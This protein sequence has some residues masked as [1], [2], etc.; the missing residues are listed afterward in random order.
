MLLPGATTVWSHSTQRGRQVPCP[1]HPR[2][3]VALQLVKAATVP[4]LEQAGD[5]SST[6]GVGGGKVQFAAAATASPHSNKIPVADN[7]P[8][9]SA[10]GPCQR[11]FGSLVVPDDVKDT[12]DVQQG[13]KRSPP[14]YGGTVDNS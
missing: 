7:Q 14:Y 4:F 1:A 12:D 2:L 3:H 10:S 9:S 8:M 6:L 5:H 11:Q 13:C